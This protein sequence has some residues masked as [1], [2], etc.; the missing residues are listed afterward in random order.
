MSGNVKNIG[1]PEMKDR[2]HMIKDDAGQGWDGRGRR[3]EDRNLYNTF[4]GYGI[5]NP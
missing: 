5:G 4:L 3:T 2:E 1:C